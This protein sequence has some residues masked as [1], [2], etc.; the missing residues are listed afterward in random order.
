ML[1]YFCEPFPFAFPY[2]FAFL[3]PITTFLRHH[4]I[5]SIF[6]MK[7]LKPKSLSHERFLTFSLQNPKI[8]LHFQKKYFVKPDTFDFKFLPAFLL[9]LYPLHHL[10]ISP[11]MLLNRKNREKSLCLKKFLKMK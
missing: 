5:V 1:P 9:Q 11:H 2:H 4:I 3:T 7:P 6:S 10:I 8:Y